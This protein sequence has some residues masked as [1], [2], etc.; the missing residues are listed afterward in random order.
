MMDT[1]LAT[2]VSG[3]PR[4]S[5]YGTFTDPISSV[6]LQPMLDRLFARRL[7]SPMQKS[8]LPHWYLSLMYQNHWGYMFL[9]TML[10]VSTRYVHASPL[11]V[12]SAKNIVKSLLDFFSHFGMPH[13]IQTDGTSYFVGNV[14]KA[15][16]TEWGIQHRVF[17]PYHP[18]TQGAVERSHQTTKSILRKYALQFNTH[19]DDDLPYLLFALREVPNESTGFSPSELVFAHEVRRPLYVIRDQHLDNTEKSIS[20]GDLVSNVKVRMRRCKQLVE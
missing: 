14:F 13:R 4:T 18:Q 12:I 10:D 7:V 1:F 16:L 8:L 11:R 20:L 6:M 9:L 5:Y 2:L 3:K 19:W 15:A 17:S